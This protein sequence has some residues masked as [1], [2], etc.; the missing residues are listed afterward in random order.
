M[1]L[2]I[3][4]I[5]LI[6]SLRAPQGDPGNLTEDLYA[7]PPDLPPLRITDATLEWGLG[8]WLNTSRSHLSGGA[9]LGDLDGDGMLDLVLAG[10]TV[11]IFFGDGTRFVPA[12]GVPPA[13]RARP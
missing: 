6:G 1:F 8:D 10:G 9:A 4:P 5:A 7:L 12:T 2:A 11:G 13:C 3:I